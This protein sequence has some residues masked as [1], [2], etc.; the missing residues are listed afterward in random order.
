[1]DE[2]GQVALGCHVR[3]CDYND[4]LSHVWHVLDIQPN[5]PGERAGLHPVT[6]YIIG[7]HGCILHDRDSFYELV[8]MNIGRTLT[9]FVFSSVLNNIRKVILTPMRGWGGEGWYVGYIMSLYPATQFSL[10]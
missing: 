3:F 9:L 2:D 8:E 6:D 10:V 4:A 5:S 7:A 1:L